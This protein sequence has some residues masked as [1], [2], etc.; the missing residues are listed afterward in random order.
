MS[1][2]RALDNILEGNLDEMRQNFSSALTTKAV[3]KLEERK[4]EIAK[5][6]FGQMQEGNQLDELRKLKNEKDVVDY[7]G[8][9]TKQIR[10][11]DAYDLSP[12]GD[13]KMK[14]GEKRTRGMRYLIGKAEKAKK[15]G[16]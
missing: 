11:M 12:E 2:K 6:Y 8:K 9:A 1:I 3:E 7:V 16:K 13:K 14:T 10:D 5:N 15:K 4:I